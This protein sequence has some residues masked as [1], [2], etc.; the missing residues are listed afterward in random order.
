MLAPPCEEKKVKTMTRTRPVA[1]SRRRFVEL[2]GA[3]GVGTALAAC[4]PQ[5]PDAS[6][7]S[8]PSAPGATGTTPKRGGTLTA[9]IEEDLANSDPHKVAGRADSL[10]FAYMIAESLVGPDASGQVVPVLAESF[11]SDSSGKS[12]LF[13]LRKGVKF[14]NG[15]EMTAEDV[16]WS[17]DRIS[18]PKSGALQG[19]LFRQMG[20]QTTVVD[21]YTARVDITNGAG[22]FLYTM[23]LNPR[24][25]IMAQESVVGGELVK[26]ICTGPF[27]FGVWVPGS[28]IEVNRAESYWRMGADGKPL[29]Y[30]DKVRMKPVSEA[31]TRLNALLT[32]EVDFVTS[33]PNIE[34]KKWLASNAPTGVK[35]LQD[36]TDLVYYLSLNMR[37]PPFDNLKARLAVASIIDRDAINQAVFF[38]AGTTVDQPFVPTSRWYVKGDVPKPDVARAKR[39]MQEAGLGGGVDMTMLVLTPQHDQ[40]A[41]VV[42]AQLAQIGIR[43]KLDKRLQ[44]DFFKQVAERNY[45]LLTIHA[46]AILHPDRPYGYFASSHVS[47]PYAGGYNDPQLDAMLGKGR[48]EPDFTKA[49]AIYTTIYEQYVKGQ[50][51]PI[52]TLL[53]PAFEAYRD[54]VKDYSSRASNF[55]AAS[56]GSGMPKTWLAK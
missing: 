7:P 15:R 13:N 12:W 46:G 22:A 47:N 39:L 9:A 20:L 18:D 34:V 27:S 5:A 43:S 48:D 3:A 17:H 53:P 40:V 50:G 30:L 14:H 11:T 45:D 6:S 49:Q 4:F 55:W 31:T 28:S 56:D 38:G 23:A 35:L 37:R 32:G 24:T 36:P 52:Y 29:P 51:T 16:K 8:S 54:S 42:Q 33:P 44:A 1:I 2:V 26:P 25:A 19:G 10:L 41:E 21:K